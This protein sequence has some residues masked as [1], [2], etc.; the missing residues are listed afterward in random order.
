MNGVF[1]LLALPSAVWLIYDVWQVNKKLNNNH[2]ILWTL[3][4]F[5]FN[6]GAAI[7]YYFTQ[8]R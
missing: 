3:F 7:I 8:K 1:Y 2:R 4:A 5:V 6:I